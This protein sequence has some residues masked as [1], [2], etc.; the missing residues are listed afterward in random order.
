MKK[1]RT[2]KFLF[3]L[4]FAFTAISSMANDGFESAWEARVKYHDNKSAPI[5]SIFS[6]HAQNNV[7]FLNPLGIEVFQKNEGKKLADAECKEI[8]RRGGLQFGGSRSG[9][10]TIG[11]GR[12]NNES[13]LADDLEALQKV[14]HIPVPHLNSVLRFDYREANK[15]VIS[16]IEL[17]SGNEKWSNDELMW[18]MDG[19]KELLSAL[20]SI[21]SSAPPPFPVS[22]P[23][24]P[25][26]YVNNMIKILPEVNA[27]LVNSFFGLAYIDLNNGETMWTVEET[28][29]GLSHIMYDEQ[30]KHILTF[31]GNPVWLPTIPGLETLYQ[32]SKDILRID[33]RTGN[34][35][36]KS[37]YSKNYRKKKPG[38]F[39]HIPLLPDI[40]LD[41]GLIILN[42]NQIEIFDFESGTA[43]FET[44]SGDDALLGYMGY[45]P[46]SEFASPVIKDGILYRYVISNILAL[47]VSA[48]NRQPNNFRAVVEAYNIE[49]GDLL[50]TSSEFSRQKVNNLTITDGLVLIS[51]DGREGVK[52]LNAQSGELVWE[53]E[54]GRRGV[55]TNWVLGDDKLFVAEDDEIHVVEL[56]TGKVINNHD[57]RRITGTIK[58]L[59]LYNNQVFAIGERRGIAL[60]NPDNGAMFANTS[61][62]FDADV[63][64]ENEKLIVHPISPSDPLMILSSENLS[65]LGE[66]SNSRRRSGISWCSDSEYVYTVQSNR[67][68]ALRFK[69]K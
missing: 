51:F 8:R 27:L 66:I 9:G 16:L 29:A 38:G 18:S 58:E 17:S 44:T 31:G 50:W 25:E 11:G 60:I 34:I 59:Q 3:L 40:R 52:A 23:D 6:N 22:L 39:D 5:I 14:V 64:F 48:G 41:N 35:I 45:G 68:E 47:G 28:A 54:L 4:V 61:T 1:Q 56:K 33:T 46:A 43:L 24:Y 36:W 32:L 69:G 12:G 15:E 30:S 20:N 26:F 57:F 62:G 55:T 67:V 2:I 10:I 19:A 13:T 49:T 37:T 53:L 7:A 42:F 63:L 21:S 65:K